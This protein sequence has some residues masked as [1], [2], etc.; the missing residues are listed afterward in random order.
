MTTSAGHLSDP[1]GAVPRR[2]M[3]PSLGAVVPPPPEGSPSSSSS[4]SFA[5]PN[6]LMQRADGTSPAGGDM[7]TGTFPHLQPFFAALAR[8]LANVSP[9]QQQTNQSQ[10]Q[11]CQAPNSVPSNSNN[12]VALSPSPFPFAFPGPFLARQQNAKEQQKQQQNSPPIGGDAQQQQQQMMANW[13]NMLAMAHGNGGTAKSER[14]AADATKTL[15]SDSEGN[16]VCPACKEPIG[17]EPTQWESHLEAERSRLRSEIESLRTAV[18]GIVTSAAETTTGQ[19]HNEQKERVD[20]AEMALERIRESQ[21]RRV[22]AKVR[23]HFF[24]N[25]PIITMLIKNDDSSNKSNIKSKA[26]GNEG[27]A[28]DS[29]KQRED[30][31]TEAHGDGS[32]ARQ[33]ANGYTVSP[34]SALELARGFE[35]KEE[36]EEVTIRKSPEGMKRSSPGGMKRLSPEAIKRMSPEWTKRISAEEI[37]RPRMEI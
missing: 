21:R 23:G 22:T 17:K 8:N 29:P 1:A 4:P 9:Q 24:T 19:A 13:L 33:S 30:N 14:T 35:H 37:K 34:F 12:N 18:H 6:Q 31:A 32:G 20:E 28:R 27:A 2:K 26:N 3:V 25:S 7:S 5:H 15:E 10:S 36:D 11:R 16:S